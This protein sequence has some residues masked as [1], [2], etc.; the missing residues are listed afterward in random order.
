M[1]RDDLLRNLGIA[2]SQ[3][4]ALRRDPGGEEAKKRIEAVLHVVWLVSDALERDD[5]GAFVPD[6]Q[7]ELGGE[8]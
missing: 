4:L 3:L 7:I 6:G 2:Q 1:N 8:G 5:V